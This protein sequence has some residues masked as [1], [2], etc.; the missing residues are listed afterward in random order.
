MI[1]I[2]LV[3]SHGELT[4]LARMSLVSYI[5]GGFDPTIWTY[6]PWRS[7]R[8]EVTL[9]NASGFMSSNE[10]HRRRFAPTGQGALAGDVLQWRINHALGGWVGHLDVT[11]QRDVLELEGSDYVLGP[12]HRYPPS[13]ALWKAPRGSYAVGEALRRV[14]GGPYDDWHAN[15]RTFNGV[16]DEAGLLPF[17]NVNL[18]NDFITSVEPLRRMMRA[19]SLSTWPD[20]YSIHWWGSAPELWREPAERGS[21][22]DLLRKELLG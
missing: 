11:L 15:M 19:G 9:A 3:W 18:N 12:H 20:N 6:E 13:M 14:E 21:H 4:E 22:F 5:R 17:V 8:G 2:H 16:I 7:I 10:W 1:P